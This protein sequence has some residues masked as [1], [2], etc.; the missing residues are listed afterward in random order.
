ML[1]I[2]AT[3]F[4]VI[5][6]FSKAMLSPKAI[7]LFIASALLAICFSFFN[8]ALAGT[9]V[10][11][12]VISLTTSSQS[13]I[14]VTFGQIFKD[15]DVPAGSGISATLNGQPIPLQVD[16][17]AINSDGSLRHAVLTAEIPTLPGDATE[18]FAIST[19]SPSTQASSVTLSQLLSTQ[20][21]ATFTATIGGTTY[22]SDARQLLQAASAN[23]LCKPWG[24]TC[25]VWLSGPL[26]TEWIVG[27][28]VVAPNGSPNPNLAVYFDVRAYSNSSQNAVS[29]VRTNVVVENTWAYTPQ[30]DL[31]Y[32]AN[33]SSGSAT[34]TSPAL[35]QYS[36]TRWHKILWWNN[37]QPYVYLQSNTQYIQ[38]TGAVSRYEILQPDESF[39]NSVRQTC[40]PLDHCDQTQDMGNTG[41]QGG[42]GPLPRWTTTYIIDPDIRAYRWMLADA[43]AAGTYSFHFRDRTTGSPLSI[44][45]HPYV[46]IAAWGYANGVASRY[47]NTWGKDLLP[48]CTNCGTAFFKTGNP[49][50]FN[51]AHHPSIG[52][53]PYMVTGDFYYLQE[54][55]FVASYLELW[56]NPKYRGSTKGLIYDAEGQTRGKA[57]TLR[58]VGDA[59]YLTP[60][61]A[62]MKAEFNA[63]INNS[64]TDF[65][66]K[67]VDSSTSNPLGLV[68]NYDYS[69]NGGTHNGASPWQDD[70][71][72]WAVGHL[73]D[74][75]F[76]NAGQLLD[77]KARFQIGLMT[78]WINN[79]T[80]GYCWLEASA[81]AL[82]AKDASGAY[83]G[84]FPALYQAN[85]PSL[86]GLSCN[87]SSMISALGSLQNKTW[88]SGE[89]V[90]YPYSPTGYPANLQIGLA[91]AAQSSDPDA[92]TA[93]K[94]FQGRSVQPTPPQGYNDYP[95]FAVLPRYLPYIPIITIYASPN[96]VAAAGD[97]TTL[98]WAASDATA[99]SAPWAGTTATAG[100]LTVGPIKAQ[101][102]YQITCTNASGKTTR[103][104]SIAISNATSNTTATSPTTSA[105]GTTSSTTSQKGAGGMTWLTLVIL[106]MFALLRFR[107]DVKI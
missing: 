55:D 74:Q 32:T 62:P 67:T 24:K 6:I 86:Y 93:W 38:A 78:N 22:T 44:E 9:V 87:S 56:A 77:W 70:F 61:S 82:Q 26:V 91:M 73:M 85:F 48:N 104:V 65:L 11:N 8:S 72:T 92:Q 41:A 47:P 101:T 71:L 89:M 81:Y 2:R 107:R 53:V 98:Q 60:D 27:G 63:D 94:T 25:N 5:P 50:K 83:I 59:A 23:S 100:Q 105:S 40:P 54:M 88:Q 13:N 69:A 12:H 51:N 75:G 57:W 7:F 18:Q 28:P 14:P 103:A 33:L 102:S 29:Y 17:K 21:D 76:A 34:Y 43:N 106:G 80:Q 31:Q 96:P 49:Y 16:T 15:G 52:Y 58:S 99:C 68:S 10:T 97:N 19:S 42:I 84:T 37:V 45:S 3:R 64:I 39:L 35:T 20:Y 30:A 90:G 1:S 46:T 95:N 79:P 36:Y 66:Q 4:Q